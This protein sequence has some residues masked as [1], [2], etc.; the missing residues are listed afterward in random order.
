MAQPGYLIVAQPGSLIVAQPGS[1]IVVLILYALAE[2][3]SKVLKKSSGELSEPN[4]GAEF[5]VHYG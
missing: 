1:L 4:L 2:A 5:L 3:E